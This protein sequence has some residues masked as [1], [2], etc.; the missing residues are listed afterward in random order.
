[1]SSRGRWPSPLFSL[2]RILHIGNRLSLQ[3]PVCVGVLVA[4]AVSAPDAEAKA[5]S[6]GDRIPSPV[7]SCLRQLA[8]KGR[9]GVPVATAPV[10]TRHDAGVPEASGARSG[11]VNLP[12]CGGAETERVRCAESCAGLCVFRGDFAGDGTNEVAF[13]GKLPDGGHVVIV[14]PVPASAG[15]GYQVQAKLPLR[16][17]E[18]ALMSVAEGLRL[19]KVYGSVWSVPVTQPSL[20]AR[21]RLA[22]MVLAWRF[23][24]DSWEGRMYAVVA[25]DS[26]YRLHRMYTVTGDY[27]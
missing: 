13:A 3:V 17:D 4:L 6:A 14:R 12:G 8:R 27:D 2:A 20:R 15:G 24:D 7:A 10:V 5:A 23:V 19:A 1:M 9:E 11:E 21:E 26:G 22:L 18:L 25:G 16:A